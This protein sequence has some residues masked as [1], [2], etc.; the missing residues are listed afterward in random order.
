MDQF[1]TANW[2]DWQERLLVERME[3]RFDSIYT[4]LKDTKND[5]EAVLFILLAKGFVLNQNGANFFS[6]VK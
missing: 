4:L 1:L 2:L 5:W 3:Y 6:M